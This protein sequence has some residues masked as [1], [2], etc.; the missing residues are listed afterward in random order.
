MESSRHSR[1]RPRER[2]AMWGPNAGGH[3]KAHIGRCLEFK[4]LSWW[5]W[6]VLNYETMN[7]GKVK[8]RSCCAIFLTMSLFNKPLKMHPVW[9]F[10]TR[11][12]KAW[13][14]QERRTSALEHVWHNMEEFF[15]CYRCASSSTISEEEAWWYPF[16][17]LQEL[18]ANQGCQHTEHCIVIGWGESHVPPYP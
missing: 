1:S 13:A 15:S 6:C 5:H 4:S 10:I 18:A 7:Y 11:A 14:Q 12:R 3:M 8:M 9:I 16:P 2:D 17:A